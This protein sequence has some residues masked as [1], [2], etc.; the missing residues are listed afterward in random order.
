MDIFFNESKKHYF[1]LTFNKNKRFHFE[2]HV[3]FY[4]IYFNY[5]NQNLIVIDRRNFD[6]YTRLQIISNIHNGTK[7]FLRNFFS[8]PP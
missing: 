2:Q 7:E 1:I 4:N 3:N 8:D 6:K 5:F